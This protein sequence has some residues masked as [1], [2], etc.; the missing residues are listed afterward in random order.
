MLFLSGS[1]V[2]GRFRSSTDRRVKFPLL[3]CSEGAARRTPPPVDGAAPLP[4]RA[5]LA[6]LPACPRGVASA[7]DVTEQNKDATLVMQPSLFGG[8]CGGMNY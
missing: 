1:N 2:L 6:S 3:L 5:P 7:E 8:Q 4:P